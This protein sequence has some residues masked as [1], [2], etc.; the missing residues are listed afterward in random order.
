MLSKMSSSKI[1][2]NITKDFILDM[3]PHHEA[4]V[5]MS[6]NLLKYNI[7]SKLALIA[8]NIIRVQENGIKEMR[9]IYQTTNIP[10]NTYLEVLDYIRNYNDILNEMARGMENSLNIPNI[11]LDFISEMIPHH[12]GAIKMCKNLLNFKIDERLKN[13]AISIINFQSQGVKELK[14]IRNCILNN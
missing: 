12:E 14:E 5:L 6:K 4:A 1:T 7:D 13:L 11:N 8:K 10:N 9:L 3:I 2:G